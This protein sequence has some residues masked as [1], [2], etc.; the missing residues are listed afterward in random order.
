MS[1]NNDAEKLETLNFGSDVSQNEFAAFTYFKL[2]ILNL[3]FGVLSYK[4]LGIM[5]KP[6]ENMQLCHALRAAV[7]EHCQS[8]C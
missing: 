6:P 5:Q 2:Q 4:I 3:E 7:F 8:K 1:K